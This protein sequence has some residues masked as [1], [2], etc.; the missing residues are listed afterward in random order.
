VISVDSS[1]ANARNAGTPGL[2]LFDDLDEL[3]V[4]A[5]VLLELPFADPPGADVHDRIVHRILQCRPDA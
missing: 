2:V 3:G 1:F 5:P 4:E